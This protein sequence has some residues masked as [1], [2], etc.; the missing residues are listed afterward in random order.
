M[1][2]F[3]PIYRPFFMNCR[4]SFVHF[5][6]WLPGSD[7]ER[8][9]RHADAERRT[10]V[11]IVPVGASLLAKRPGQPPE[12]GRLD[13]YL[14][15]QCGLPPRSTPAHH[16]SHDRPQSKSVPIASSRPD[17]KRESDHSYIHLWN[18]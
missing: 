17:A 5:S 3:G 7:A 4:T 8:P 18:N 16:L 12:T 14:R 10:I 9:E 6:A 1:G 15:E 2:L 11:E 13:Q